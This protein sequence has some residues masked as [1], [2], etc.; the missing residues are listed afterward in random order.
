MSHIWE[1]VSRGIGGMGCPSMSYLQP[2]IHEDHQE[3]MISGFP[4]ASDEADPREQS[5]G[6]EKN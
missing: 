2:W 4:S 1:I 5:N 6:Q 3:G